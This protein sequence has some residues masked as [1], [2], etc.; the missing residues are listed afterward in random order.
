MTALPPTPEFTEAPIPGYEGFYAATSDGEIISL[1]RTIA[2]S[3][4]RPLNLPRR[5]MKP[6]QASNG[7]LLVVLSKNG[8][9]KT[10]TVHSL[11][12]LTFHGERPAG[13]QV[14]HKDGIKTNNAEA[15]LTYGTPADNAKDKVEHGTHQKGSRAPNSKLTEK[16]VAEIR[17]RLASGKRQRDVAAE[18]G[19]SKSLIAAISTRKIWQHV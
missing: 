15:N 5:V 13:Q 8:E 3:N 2:R 19:V 6:R 10:H 12:A 18:F 4:G 14:R 11:I 7:Y 1:A 9:T 17:A 16:K